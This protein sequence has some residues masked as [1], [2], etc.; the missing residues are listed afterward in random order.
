MHADQGG[1][2]KICG[3]TPSKPLNVDHDHDTDE[4][5]GLLCGFCNTVLG[6]S[7]ESPD[8]L[9]R[10]VLYLEGNLRSAPTT[11]LGDL[12]KKRVDS[13]QLAA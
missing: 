9:R 10:C 6:L 4:V 5:R 3:A 8:I 13:G 7:L 12:S 1:R 2:C 11:F